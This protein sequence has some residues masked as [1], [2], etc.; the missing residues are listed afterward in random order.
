ME[1]AAS[2]SF[3]SAAQLFDEKLGTTFHGE[4]LPDWK[5]LR[6]A[7]LEE[8]RLELDAAKR[9]VIAARDVLSD[10]PNV[11]R[12]QPPCLCAPRCPKGIFSY[13]ME[14]IFLQFSS[15]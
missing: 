6:Q 9:L 4:A 14:I 15:F 5:L 3:V 1:Q 11:L 10:E 12:L 2:S 13:D 8:K 7:L